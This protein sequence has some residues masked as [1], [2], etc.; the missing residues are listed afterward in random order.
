MISLSY[1]N[2]NDFESTK[3]S[4]ETARKL[5][6]KLPE[7]EQFTLKYVYYVLNQQP[8]KAIAVVKMWS[9][10]FPDDIAAYITLAER[11]RYK[12]MFEEAIAE[13]KTIL[14]LDPERYNILQTIAGLYFQM[15]VFDSS[16]AYYQKYARALPQQAESYQNLGDYYSMRGDMEM[17]KQNF[18]KALLLADATEE[19]AIKIDLANVHMH[20]GEFEEAFKGFSDALNSAATSIDSLRVYNA[21]QN[22]YL[23]LGQA[24]NKLLC[25]QNGM[26]IL[27]KLLPPKDYLVNAVFSIE[28]YIIAGRLDEAAAILE[29]VRKKLEPPID[30]I[31]PFGY[32]FIYAETGDTAKAREAIIGAEELIEAFGEDMLRGNVVYAKARINEFLG[33]Y[34]AAIENYREGLD[35][36]AT[37]Y[38]FYRGISRC[39]RNMEEYDKAEAEIEKA[40]LLRP[41]NP[42]NIYEAALLYLETG[43]NEK[44]MQ[45]LSKAVGIWENADPDYERANEAKEKYE[46][47]MQ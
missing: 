11:Y 27:K 12:N 14:R 6:H 35:M 13:Y 16:L 18:E 33:E 3:S 40:L 34:E 39:Y 31:V 20:S 28:P 38:S 5:E 7:R 43:E 46:S 22:Y 45:L 2:N 36:N 8:E 30:K 29:E 25:Y 4:L 1:F 41:F 21:L 24:Q 42:M 17:A 32:L 37:R 47:L 26:A 44:G 19:H 9:E 23:N 15:G 10:L